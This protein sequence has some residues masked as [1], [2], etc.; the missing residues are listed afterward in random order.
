[1]FASYFVTSSIAPERAAQ[2]ALLVVA[3]IEGGFILSRTQRSAAPLRQ[4]AHELR[5]VVA[6]A[7]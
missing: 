5:A 3:S 1:V 2:L 4:I 7:R 6:A